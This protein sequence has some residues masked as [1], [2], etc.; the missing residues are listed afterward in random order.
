[1]GHREILMFIGTQFSN[2]YIAED[3]QARA[4]SYTDT[5]AKAMTYK[6][7]LSLYVIVYPYVIA[8]AGVSLSS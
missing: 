6:D 3:T 5:P 1:M 4:V 7:S 8:L 2:L